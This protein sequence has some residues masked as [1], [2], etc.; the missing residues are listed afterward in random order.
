MQFHDPGIKTPQSRDFGTGKFARIQG[1]RDRDN[2]GI[3]RYSKA[4]KDN[5]GTLSSFRIR[6][7]QTEY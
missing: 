7:S 2:F 3:Q 5:I 6:P 4:N 1:F